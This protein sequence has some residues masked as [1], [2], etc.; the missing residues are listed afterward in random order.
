M[1]LS[2]KVEKE[3]RDLMGI[4]YSYI[5][6]IKGYKGFSCPT[7]IAQPSRITKRGCLHIRIKVDTRLVDERRIDIDCIHCRQ[8]SR[9]GGGDGRM[10]GYVSRVGVLD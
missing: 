6:G 5:V 8:S 10:T 9:Y 2:S 1:I 4:C 7:S 3:I